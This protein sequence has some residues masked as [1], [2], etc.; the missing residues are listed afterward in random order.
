MTIYL[1]DGCQAREGERE[2][3]RKK[4]KSQQERTK[5]FHFAL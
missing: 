3:K 1:P 2:K 4:M 5:N